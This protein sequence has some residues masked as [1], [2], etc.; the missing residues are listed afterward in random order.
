MSNK[1]P[2]HTIIAA[3]SGDTVPIAKKLAHYTLYIRYWAKGDDWIYQEAQAKLMYAV[4]LYFTPRY[5]PENFLELVQ[6]D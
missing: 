2:Y 6:N 1:I 3:K 4:M 5:L